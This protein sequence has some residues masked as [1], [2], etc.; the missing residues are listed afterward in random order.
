[1]IKEN[2]DS[3][4]CTNIIS[5]DIEIKERSVVPVIKNEVLGKVLD[6]K[7]TGIPYATVIIKGTS[8]G[9]A[10]D[11]VGNFYL[12]IP[13]EQTPVSLVASC[14]GYETAVLF[15]NERSDQSQSIILKADS[16][17]NTGIVVVGYESVRK[18]YVTGAMSTIKRSY[19][20]KVRDYFV[21]DSIKVFPNPA[22]AG[23]AIKIEWKKTEVGEYKIDL[24]SLQSQ[25]IKSSLAKIENEINVF[26][27]QIPIINPGSYLLRM[28]NKKSG[29]KH[30]AKIIIQ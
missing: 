3:A 2:N 16:T 5:G 13:G 8:N 20:Q 14:V 28:T 7:G 19:L 4:I 23:D 1:M 11:S 18:C 26:T 15:V 21:R 12:R 6:E 9:V 10:C 29:K 30:T 22:K 17:A 24:Y 27:F 25:L